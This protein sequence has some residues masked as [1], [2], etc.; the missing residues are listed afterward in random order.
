MVRG[1]TCEVLAHHQI[2][3]KNANT[4][5]RTIWEAGGSGREELK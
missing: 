4:E 2:S 5:D 3:L 1:S